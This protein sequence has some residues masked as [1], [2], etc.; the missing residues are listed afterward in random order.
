MIGLD[1]KG[2]WSEIF[3]LRV[4]TMKFGWK[5][6][7]ASEVFDE[8]TMMKFTISLATWPFFRTNMAT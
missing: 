2:G 3:D 8:I 4:G 5:I 7:F 6:K 1:K